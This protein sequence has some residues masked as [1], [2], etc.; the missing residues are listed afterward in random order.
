VIAALALAALAAPGPDA[1]AAAPSAQSLR[2]SL[3]LVVVDT[4]RRIPDEPKIAG[5]LRIVDHGP[6]RRNLVRDRAAFRDRI[7][8]EVRGYSSQQLFPKKQYAVE[9][10]GGDAALLGLPADDDWVLA[11]P[12]NDKSL[13]RNVLAFRTARSIGRY[14]PRSRFVE[15]VLNGDY[16]GVYALTQRIELGKGRVEVDEEGVSGGYILE[17]TSPNQSRGER[18]FLPPVTRRPILYTDPDRDE[19]SGRE[20]RWIRSWVGRFERALYRGGDWRRYVDVPSAVD[21]VLL[22]ELFKNEDGFYSS[23]YLHKGRGAGLAFGP[24]WDFDV[25]MGNSIHGR[26]R[27][28]PGLMLPDRTW[29]ERLYRKR[30]F[31]R[32]MARRWRELRRDGLRRD[33]MRAIAGMSGQL[34]EPA[35]R[36]FARWRILGRYVPPNPRDPRTGRY[37]TSWRSEVAFLRSWMGRRIAWL[38]RGLPHLAGSARAVRTPMPARSR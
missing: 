21:Y 38:D 2:A 13:M 37:R 12:Y 33:V 29:A 15:L 23:T 28:L 8:I 11:A 20:A 35:R 25:A 7:G 34:R 30:G 24:V 1:V 6:G 14:A 17:I 4:R 27:H 3:P 9:L 26:S 31:A 22:Q 10:R 36:N 18:R 19:L 16:R 32:Q 5:R